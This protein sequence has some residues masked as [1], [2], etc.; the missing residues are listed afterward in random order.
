MML[1]KMVEKRTGMDFVNNDKLG[2]FNCG[3][4]VENLFCDFHAH[5]QAFYYY[6]YYYFRF[7]LSQ[8]LVPDSCMVALSFISLR[9]QI[10]L[11]LGLRRY[12]CQSI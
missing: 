10:R 5:F 2:I 8:P 11:L 6:Y 4:S 9:L 3:M 1:T 7:S 12:L